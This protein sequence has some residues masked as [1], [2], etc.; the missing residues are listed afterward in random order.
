MAA[1]AAFVVFL[2]ARGDLDLSTSEA[3]IAPPAPAQTSAAGSLGPIVL[4]AAQLRARAGTL[5]EPVYWIGPRAGRAYELGRT[6]DG[7]VSVRYVRPGAPPGAADENA[8]VVGTYPSKN[9]YARAKR[10]VA[11]SPSLVYRDLRDGGFAVV[12]PD[13]PRSVFVA[14]P[15]LDYQIEVFDPIPGE[16]Q[17]LVLSK[18]ARVG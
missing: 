15:K 8:I 18:L 4:R 12:D 16:A 17:Q 3:G 14:Y 7:K 10:A 13:R 1:A 9:A 6:A 5:R 2:A 11:S